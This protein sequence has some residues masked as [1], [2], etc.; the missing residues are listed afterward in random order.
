MGDQGHCLYDIIDIDCYIVGQ[1]IKAFFREYQIASPGFFTQNL[2][3]STKDDQIKDEFN[4]L[5]E[6]LKS[7]ILWLLDLCIEVTYYRETNKMTIE[8]LAICFSP[9]FVRH[10]DPSKLLLLQ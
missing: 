6:P 5:N 8:N 7:M 10:Q 1:L 2:L 9:N 3:N 4:K